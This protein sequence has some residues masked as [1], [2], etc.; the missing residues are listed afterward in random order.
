MAGRESAVVAT[1]VEHTGVQ[2]LVLGLA[3]SG[4]GGDQSYRVLV[5]ELHFFWIVRVE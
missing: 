2:A 5:N 4:Q 3:E 1:R